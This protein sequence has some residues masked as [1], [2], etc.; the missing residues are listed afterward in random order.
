MQGLN[1]MAKTIGHEATIPNPALSSPGHSAY[2]AKLGFPAG[3][4]GQVAELGA[5]PGELVMVKRA[6]A[7]ANVP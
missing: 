4:E 3:S 5:K 1:D 6:A 2:V 7:A